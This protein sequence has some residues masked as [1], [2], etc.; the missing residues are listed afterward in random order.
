M[1]SQNTTRRRFRINNMTGLINTSAE[2]NAYITLDPNA[3]LGS[4][5]SQVGFEF[6]NIDNFAPINRGGLSKTFGFTFEKNVGTALIT[7]LYRFIQSNGNRYFMVTFGNTLATLSGSTLTTQSTALAN[8]AFIDFETA[9]DKCIVCDG[10]NGP[11]FFDGSTVSVLAGSPPTGARQSIFYQNRLWMFSATNNQSLLYYSD[12]GDIQAG[13]SS[14]FVQCDVNDGQKITA[15]AKFFIPGQLEPVILVGKERSIGMVTGNGSSG[16]PYT[17][18][19]ITFDVGIP[20]FRQIVQYGQDAAC[21]TPLGVLSYQAAI[22][23]INLQSKYISQRVSNQFNTLSEV[24]LPNAFSWFEGQ[25]RRIAFAV[26]T[27]NS[28]YPDLI[29]YYD[30]E[31][32]GWYKKSG[33]NITAVMVDTDGT[34]YHGDHL[35][36][37][38]RHDSSL[39]SYDGNPISSVIQTPYLDFYEPDILKRITYAS[40]FIRGNGSY[41]LGIS[42]T[43]D[44]GTKQGSSHNVS[45]TSGNYI[46]GGGLWTDNLDTYQWGNSPIKKRKF[47]PKGI[48]NSISF[49]F[50]QTGAEQPAD[51]FELDLEVEYLDKR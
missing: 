3:N 6:K 20:G 28:S 42:S 2:E 35:G 22:R 10:V 13:Y 49:S 33:F 27:G 44:Y 47:F 34:V 4:G 31:L 19:K 11:I 29:W 21:L 51:I 16:N 7:G 46:W 8:N 5:L 9:Y 24:T 38:Y 17:F 39:Y 18:Q 40:I 26:A 32:E 41:N 1:S 12:P 36:N 43:L 25:Y 14:N 50:T 37:I 30:Y 45:L 15:I 23:N 48:F